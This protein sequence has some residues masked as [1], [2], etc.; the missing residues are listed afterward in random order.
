MIYQLQLYINKF[1]ILT[2]TNDRSTIKQTT[3]RT[4]LQHRWGVQIWIQHSY[5]KHSATNGIKSHRTSQYWGRVICARYRSRFW[6][7]GINLD[8]EQFHLGGHGHQQRHAQ[9]R[10]CKIISKGWSHA[11]WYRA[12]MES[13]TGC[14]WRRHF[15]FHNSMAL[16][17]K[18]KALQS[19]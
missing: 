4:I 2:L 17:G 14:L 9:P 1:I 19:F 15:Y 5:P 13:Q 8:W 18:Q 10:R 12:R 11:S 3:T 7:I 6:N 16:C